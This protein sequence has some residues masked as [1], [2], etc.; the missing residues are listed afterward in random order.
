MRLQQIAEITGGQAFFPGSVKDLDGVYDKVVAEVRA[1]YTL[2]YQSTN[3]KTD[4]AWRRIDIKVVRKPG[5]DV[6]VRAR[7][8][9][10]APYKK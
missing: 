3:E 10:F 6:R 4:G 1:Q 9:Y 2:G 7:R 8:G 5:R